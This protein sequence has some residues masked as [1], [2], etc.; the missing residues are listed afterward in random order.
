MSDVVV[1]IEATPDEAMDTQSADTRDLALPDSQ[2]DL[3]SPALAA[4]S[5]PDL[6]IDTPQE[7]PRDDFKETG[8]LKRVSRG[9]LKPLIAVATAQYFIVAVLAGLAAWAVASEAGEAINAKL[10]PLLTALKRF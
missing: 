7:L 3:E 9:L 8:P 4:D 1:H 6:Q 5:H 2:N 10:E